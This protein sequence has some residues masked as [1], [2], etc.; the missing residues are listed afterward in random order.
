MAKEKKR[1][2]QFKKLTHVLVRKTAV[3][4][5]IVL[6]KLYHNLVFEEL[7]NKM[8]HLGSKKIVELARK[9]DFTGH[10]SRKTLS[11]TL[12]NSADVLYLRNQI[13]Q[14]KLC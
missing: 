3:S 2:R 7:H 6:P 13:F 11:F 14:K 12:G 10:T 9:N 4:T 1:A 8:G 5:Q